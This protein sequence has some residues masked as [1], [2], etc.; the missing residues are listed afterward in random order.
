MHK[1]RKERNSQR[2]KA[3]ALPTYLHSSGCSPECVVWCVWRFVFWLGPHLH[4]LWTKGFSL[5]CVLRCN[6]TLV[7]TTVPAHVRF[8]P[9]V[10]PLVLSEVW[11]F[12]N[13]SPT[14][15]ASPLCVSSDAVWLEAKSTHKPYPLSVYSGGFKGWHPKSL[16]YSPYVFKAF[17]RVSSDVWCM[18][19]WTKASPTLCTQKM[20]PPHDCL[21]LKRFDFWLKPVECG[22]YK[23][24]FSRSWDFYPL[25]NVVS[26]P[27]A[28][29]LG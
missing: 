27:R 5:E 25:W 4:S 20:F 11:F 26:F 16:A 15:R 7:L 18:W 10:N 21:H 24:D 12:T 19:L 3:E 17:P 6:F 28:Y 8:M 29:P 9:S 2:R 13:T 1:P 14:Q 23:S 22:L